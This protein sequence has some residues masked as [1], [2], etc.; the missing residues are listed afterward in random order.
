MHGG[1]KPAPAASNPAASPGSSEPAIKLNKLTDA[2]LQALATCFAK[3]KEEKFYKL[4]ENWSTKF[5]YT[6]LNASNV[7]ST[8]TIFP[9]IEERFIL[10]VIPKALVDVEE[11]DEFPVSVELRQ[12]YPNPFNPTTTIS[13][14]MPEEANVKLSVF[15]IVGQPVSVLIQESKSKGEHTLE[16]DASD[17]P[18]G[19]YIY[20]LEVGAKIMTRKMTLVK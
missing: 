5:T 17:M 7:E 8:E 10:R 13:F 20:Q 1:R 12:N 11:V 18:S 15:N 16:W 2:F 6:D 9:S 19:I 3:D 4:N 14:Y